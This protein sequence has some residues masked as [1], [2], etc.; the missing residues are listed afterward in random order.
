MYR[1]IILVVSQHKAVPRACPYMQDTFACACTRTKGQ[2]RTRRYGIL[3]TR[4]VHARISSSVLSR[5]NFTHSGGDK[6]APGKR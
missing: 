3:Y 5:A 6:R 4:Q 2:E 1:Q